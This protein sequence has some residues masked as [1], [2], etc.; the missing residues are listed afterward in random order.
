M[1][2]KSLPSSP[3]PP[4]KIIPL[5]GLKFCLVDVEDY[6]ELNRHHWFAKKSSSRYYAVRKI[7]NNGKTRFIRMHRVLMH[8]ARG[9]VCHHRNGHSLDNRKCNLENMSRG[10]HDMAHWKAGK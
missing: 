3:V 10:L 2:I 4:F 6:D 1:R 7:T 8:T 5:G 9:F